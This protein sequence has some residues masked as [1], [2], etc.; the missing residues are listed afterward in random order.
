MLMIKCYKKT[1]RKIF[2][3]GKKVSRDLFFS[4]ADFSDTKIIIHEF[5]FDVIATKKYLEM[6]LNVIVCSEII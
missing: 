2:D 6:R 5:K 3:C 4:N 1:S